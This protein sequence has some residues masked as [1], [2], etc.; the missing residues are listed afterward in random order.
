MMPLPWR[1]PLPALLAF[2]IL[3]LS[4][5]SSLANADEALVAVAAN[6][7]STAEALAAR[8]EADSDH[9]LVI[10]SGSTGKLY[11][12]IK[13]GAPFDLFLAADVARPGLLAA[14]GDSPLPPR[15]YASGQ[16]G[17][18]IRGEQPDAADLAARLTSLRRIAVAN[19]SLAPYGVA[20]MAVIDRLAIRNRLEGRLAFGENVAQ[21]YALV[22]AGAADGGLIA[23]SILTDG[24]RTSESWQIP[25]DW[26]PAIDQDAVLLNTGADNPAAQ[27]FFD[28]LYSPPARALIRARGYLVPDS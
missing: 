14:A 18:W 3:T 24:G 6:F 16:L 4:Q 25:S 5:Q 2:L 28:Y 26:H 9:E 19:P 10:I 1:R 15:T 7:A 23:W 27:A 11:T 21:A 13:N 8:F 17:L 12:Q 22:A 20:A